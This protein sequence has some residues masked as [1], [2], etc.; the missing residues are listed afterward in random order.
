VNEA[1]RAPRKGGWRGRTI[2]VAAALL[3]CYCLYGC[4][5]M[6]MQDRFIFPRDVPGARDPRSPVPR[7]WEQVTVRGED[8]S[9]VPAWLSLPARRAEGERVPAVMFF[10][11]N[12]EVI[13]EIAVSDLVEMYGPMGVAVLLVEYRGYGRAGGA[14]SEAAIAAD[15][16]K[17]Y[18]LLAARPEIDPARI[19]LHGRSLGGGAACDV[20][21]ERKPAAMILQSTFTSVRAMASSMW[22][23]GFIV[24]HPFRNDQIIPTLDIPILFMH[25]NRDDIIPY[26]H[27]EALV[28]LAKRGRLV[29]Q[30]CSHNDFPGDYGAYR[31]EIEKFL[32]ENS[33]LK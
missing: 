26:A 18:D 24:R 12:A 6:A 8:G 15:S 29:S 31:R 33:I 1:G 23:P 10:H 17:F 3:V 32:R 9:T 5:L 27:S 7:G 28:K 21:R 13:D 22:V 4:G 25:G 14:P 11:G 16:V 2:R 19:V 20:A 30:D